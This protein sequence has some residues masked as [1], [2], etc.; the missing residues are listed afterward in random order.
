MLIKNLSLP[1]S[2]FLIL[3][4][5]QTTLGISKPVEEKLVQYR[6]RW[7]GHIQRRPAVT[8][9]VSNL[10]DYITHMFKIP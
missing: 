7:L 1:I 10:K 3:E 4:K 8:H 6:L 5:I 2:K 9:R